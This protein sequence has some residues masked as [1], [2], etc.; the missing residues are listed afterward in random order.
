MNAADSKTGF[1]QT[2]DVFLEID[3]SNS[4][5]GSHLSLVCRDL[6]DKLNSNSSFFTPIHVRL[7]N[8]QPGSKT[9]SKVR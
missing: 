6:E 8:P 5:D 3:D 7:T 9:D 2:I 4:T 1:V